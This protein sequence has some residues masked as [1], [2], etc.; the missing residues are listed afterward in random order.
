M[1]FVA[2]LQPSSSPV[3]YSHAFYVYMQSPITET[4]PKPFNLLEFMRSMIIWSLFCALTDSSL[5]RFV[6]NRRRTT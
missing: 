2:T 5:G 4:M 1:L 3:Y 6:G